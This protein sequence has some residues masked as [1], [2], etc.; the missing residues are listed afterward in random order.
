M[1]AE[2]SPGVI[3]PVADAGEHDDADGE[4]HAEQ[5]GI[6]D[7]G[8][9]VLVFMEVTEEGSDLGHVTCPLVLVTNAVPASTLVR[10]ISP[11]PGEPLSAPRVYRF[12]TGFYLFLI[13]H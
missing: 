12:A 6:F 4:D 13:Y 7:E 1:A 10:I 3:S 5:R 2:E 9:A 8:R 11:A